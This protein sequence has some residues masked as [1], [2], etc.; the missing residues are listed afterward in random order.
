MPSRDRRNGGFNKVLYEWDL[1]KHPHRQTTEKPG[2]PR[3]R[4]EENASKAT[5]TARHGLEIHKEMLGETRT[6][7]RQGM[8]DMTDPPLPPLLGGPLNIN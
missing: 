7:R 1:K 2:R 3:C 6:P 4:V 8:R 5:L